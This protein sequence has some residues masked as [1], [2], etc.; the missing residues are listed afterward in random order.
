MTTDERSMRA[1]TTICGHVSDLLAEHWSDIEK[2][3]ASVE[4]ESPKMRL[5]L[6][7]TL[8]GALDAPHVTT[9]L[10]YGVRV[11][12]EVSGQMDDPRQGKLELEGE[13]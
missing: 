12:D 4:G 7:V 3:W 5:S 10:A 1:A 8:A 9:A 13:E 2:A 6:A 11:K